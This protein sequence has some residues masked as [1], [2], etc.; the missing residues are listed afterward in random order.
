MNTL[1]IGKKAK[2]SY[3][4][5][6]IITLLRRGKESWYHQWAFVV[7]RSHI[8]ITVATQVNLLPKFWAT[9]TLQ[10]T[11]TQGVEKLMVCLDNFCACPV[12]RV[13]N[14]QAPANFQAE[15]NQNRSMA[16]YHRRQNQS[17][18]SNL[19]SHRRDARECFF[20]GVSHDNWRK[21][22]KVK[23][24]CSRGWANVQIAK[25]YVTV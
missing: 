22:V 3:A 2:N 6:E 14:P 4:E 12:C 11:Q 19:A 1:G 24:C 15:N 23:N 25:K 8:P 20:P 17:A 7:Y 18:S 13:F 9:C 10:S 5:K 21:W 16:T